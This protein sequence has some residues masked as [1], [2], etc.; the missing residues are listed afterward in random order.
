MLFYIIRHLIGIDKVTNIRNTRERKEDT[1]IL[2]IMNLLL[3][4]T[5]FFW[6]KM[7]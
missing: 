6:E 7:H 2:I 3:V 1:Q 5:L 4:L